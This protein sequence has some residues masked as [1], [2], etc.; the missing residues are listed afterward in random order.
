[1]LKR[2]RQELARIAPQIDAAL[3][4]PASQDALD[5]LQARCPAPLPDDLLALYRASAGLD[6][7]AYAN[8]V[9][10]L[11]WLDIDTVIDHAR[12]APERDGFALRF[13]DAGIRQDFTQGK[14]RLEI[15]ND[16]A[17]CRLCVDLD[18]A[19]GGRHGQVIFVDDEN[20]TALLLAGSV[21]ELMN[22]FADDLAAGRYSLNEEALEDGEESLVPDDELDVVNWHQTSTWGHARQD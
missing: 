5:A 7:E 4:P 22:Q 17:R 14:S 15:G 9:F 18:P 20:E 8:F 1:M 16:G 6:P 13:T 2:V 21:G 19:P 11:S 10:G 3:L 12:A